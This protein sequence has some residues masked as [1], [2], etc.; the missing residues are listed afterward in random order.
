MEKRRLCACED[1]LSEK[2]TSEERK[3]GKP[4]WKDRMAGEVQRSGP[5]SFFPF[6]PARNRYRRFQRRIVLD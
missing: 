3:L 4:G 6:R 5:R 1:G 2:V